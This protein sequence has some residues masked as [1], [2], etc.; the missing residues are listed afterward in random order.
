MIS[1]ILLLILILVTYCVASEGAT[2]AGMLFLCV[3]LAGL[4]AMN[5]FEP[6]AGALESL[7]GPTWRPR[8]DFI[9]LVGLF[10]AL[11]F[12]LRTAAERTAAADIEIEDLTNEIGRWGF[13]ALTGY[14]TIAFL[15]TSLHTAPLPRQVYPTRIEEPLGFHAEGGNFFGLSPD[16]HWLA[17]TQFVSRKGLRRGE[18]YI[19]DA[20]RYKV[21]DYQE[22]EWPSFPLRYAARREQLAVQTISG[23]S[24]T[25]GAGGIEAVE[26]PTDPTGSGT[27]NGTGGGTNSTGGF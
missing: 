26:P 12:G 24:G 19:F 3:L 13:G 4:L 17:F 2:G 10:V 15:L 27:N 16:Y 23:G 22:A 8:W 5:F 20:P 21:G 18:N 14:V 25:G 9:A 7:G 6:V 1:G 11:V